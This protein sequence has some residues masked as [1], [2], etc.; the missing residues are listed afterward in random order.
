MTQWTFTN[1]E[2][3]SFTPPPPSTPN[4]E[5]RHVHGQ[6]APPAHQLSGGAAALGQPPA[7]ADPQEAPDHEPTNT[8]PR[9]PRG[10]HRTLFAEDLPA[11]IAQRLATYVAPP[12][13][14]EDPVNQATAA[15]VVWKNKVSP[16]K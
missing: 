2:C 10:A 14:H 11:A 3:V 5:L 16:L 8:R 15:A 9:V 4:S 12:W 13:R 6:R 7:Q 1:G